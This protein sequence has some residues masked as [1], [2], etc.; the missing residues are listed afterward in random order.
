MCIGKVGGSRYKLR[1]TDFSCLE[2][3]KCSVNIIGMII[4]NE[5]EAD[6]HSFFYRVNNLMIIF[7]VLN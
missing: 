5:I 1:A 7:T 3:N 4:I 2:G 6:G